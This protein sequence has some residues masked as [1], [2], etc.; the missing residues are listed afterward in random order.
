LWPTWFSVY[1]SAISFNLFPV[2]S[3]AATLDMGWWLAFTQQ[4]LSPCKKCQAYLGAPTV[5]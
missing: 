2:S 5:A 3:I 4:G 1:A